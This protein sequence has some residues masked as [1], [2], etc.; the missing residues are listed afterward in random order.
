MAGFVREFKGFADGIQVKLQEQ[1]ERMM[2]LDRKSMLAGA[3][4][5]L[6]AV[7]ET[8]PLHQKAFAAYLRAGDDDAL[9]SLDLEGKALS[10]AVAA[11]G[12]FLV[13]P[14]MAETIQGVLFASAS[15]TA[16]RRARDGRP[17]L[18]RRPKPA[19]R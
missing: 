14:Q 3:R 18:R 17:R 12:G 7:A 6:A 11:D 19:R 10:T 2:K 5:Q 13:A 9:R 4:P 8:E 16:P 15:W 1:D